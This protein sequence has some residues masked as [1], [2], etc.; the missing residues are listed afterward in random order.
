M[1]LAKAA[2][3]RAHKNAPRTHHDLDDLEIGLLIR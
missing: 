1:K 2:L 3:K